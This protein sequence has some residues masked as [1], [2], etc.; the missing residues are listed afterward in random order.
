VD[1]GVG[2]GDVDA[3]ELPDRARDGALD[4]IRVGH[5]GLERGRPVTQPGREL[6]EKLGLEPDER[7]VRAALVQARRGLRPY[8][9]RRSRDEHRA[10][11]D[12]PGHC[13][14]PRL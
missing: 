9:A 10:S 8:A 11:V 1:P 4:R 13:P 14:S 5:V 7:N 6:F 2:H 3:A 12:L